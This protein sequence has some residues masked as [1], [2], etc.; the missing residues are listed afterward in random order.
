MAE[1][2]R[3]RGWRRWTPVTAAVLVALPL[4]AA[5]PAVAAVDGPLRFEAE[6]GVTFELDDGRHFLDTLELRAGSDGTLLVNELPMDEYVAGVAEMP[7]RWPLEALKA[8]A[9]A[10]RTYAW[11]SIELGTFTHYDICAT[12]NCQVFRGVDVVRGSS[13]GERW[14][15]AVDE[16]SG[17]VLLHDGD[18]IL[19]RYFSTSGGRTYA[20]EEV[21]PDDTPRP[22]LT[23]V[24]DPYD[25][26]SPY[27]RW[28]A[29][30]TREEFDA[31]LAR[32]DTLAAATPV[33]EVERLG[34]VDDPAATIV[35]TGRDGTEVAVSARD[36]REFVSRLAP[37]V[38]P[39]RFPGRRADGLRPLPA[40][41]PSSR[42]EIELG[43]DEVLVR[44]RGWGHGVG[45]G[46]YGARGRADD[47]QSYEQIL[48]AYY[49]GLEP[50]TSD[51]MPERV[52]VGL[53]GPDE[54]TV[55]A[56]GTFRIVAGDVVV[57]ERALGGW[58]ARRVGDGWALSAPEG[59]GEQLEVTATRAAT[60]F[61]GGDDAVVVEAEV[62]KPVLLQLEVADV[63]GT[64]ILR[65]DLGVAEPG[66]HAATWRYED[67]EGATVDD[68]RYRVTLVGED[69]AG[70]RAGQAHEVTVERP[71]PSVAERVVD[72]ASSPS[73]L[74]AAVALAA[75]IVLGLGARGAAS[76]RARD[77]RS[78]GPS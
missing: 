45:L 78:R 29:R 77:D 6:P 23:A 62:N 58:T 39:D 27:H 66:T 3:R 48:A 71:P 10:A 20:N 65:R 11:Y 2:R 18:P 32:G 17:E 72:G 74:V 1:G 53:D 36:L 14:Q 24:D 69:A 55:R 46:Q 37:T 16:T 59:T 22:Y 54:V 15:Q 67:A 13:T 76:A 61:P 60:G 19:A 49:G 70:E 5:A 28:E 57:A 41:M 43:D 44:G 42:Y 30:F 73:A 34:D 63:A 50:T 64:T 40:T 4:L 33:A 38:F 52:R 51:A 26:V 25:E 9:V 8:Q 21:F 47:G 12:V 7:S 35:V 56:D 31:V 68:G 75:A